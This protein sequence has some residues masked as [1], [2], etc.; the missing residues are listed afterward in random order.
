M[1]KAIAMSDNVRNIDSNQITDFLSLPNIF[2][3][4]DTQWQ[5]E[6]LETLY[7]FYLSYCFRMENCLSIE[8][9]ILLVESIIQ[10]KNLI[11]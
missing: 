6:L 5:K 3:F 10:I 11:L 2:T 7:Y 4:T 8:F 9:K 1:N